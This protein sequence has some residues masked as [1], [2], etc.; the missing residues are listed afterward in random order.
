[1]I[2]YSNRRQ[3]LANAGAGFGALALAHLLGDEVRAGGNPLAAK[4]QH[5]YARAK[6]VIFLFMEGGPSHLD[7]F[8]PK[9]ALQ[10]LAGKPLPKSFK[11]VITAMGE[12][13]SPVLPS[14][15]KW[16]QHGESGLW[17]S[18][19]LPHIAQCA[20]D[21]AV[22]R[23]CWTNGINHS[24]GVCQMNTGT[25]FAGRPSLGSWVTYGLGSENESLPAFVVMQDNND[26]IANGA[27][28]WSSGFMPAVY[29]GT[30]FSVSGIPIDN[31]ETPKSVGSSRQ[32]RKLSYLKAINQRHADQRPQD[33]ELDAR[34]RSYELAFRMQTEA[35]EAI[36]LSDETAE[37]KALYGLDDENTA[38]YGRNCLLARRL[39]ER[40]V[41]FIQLY[42]GAGS[43]WDAHSGIE[44]NHTKMC[45]QMDKPVAGLLQDLKR[46]GLLDQ[47]LVVWGGEFGRTPMSEKGNGRDHNPTGFTM[48]MAGGGVQGG[49]TIGA[50]DEVGLHAVEE[51]LHVH[52]LHSTILHILGVDHKQ[53]I[54]TH[55][56]R[57]ERIDQNEGRIYRDILA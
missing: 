24:G 5:D 16:K 28:N 53:L 54:Y 32:Q 49:R 56:G 15:R 27:R 26:A 43:K 52:D 20:D 3:M 40:G 18:D 19:W 8:D 12:F 4:K 36:D 9:D 11:R 39:V 2:T 51:R 46:R 31:L 25:Q 35:P 7:L 45:G 33:S 48:F 23:S 50:T 57:P 13:D 6:S 47:T 21:L 41:R 14:K 38:K 55:K 17:I 29:Q 37:T 44:A 22:I 10:E 1:M 30:P 42:H 34:I